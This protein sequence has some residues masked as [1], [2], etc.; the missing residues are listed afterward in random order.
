MGEIKS[1][2]SKIANKSKFRFSKTG[3][4][5][6][7]ISNIKRYKEGSTKLFG[8]QFRFIDSASFCGM[9]NEIILNEIYKFSCN[10]PSPLII[11]CGANVGVSVLYFKKIYP[12]SRILAFE[13]DPNVFN[14]LK[15]NLDRFKFDDIHLM[16]KAVAKES[17]LVH[18]NS[19]G[20]DGGRI[21]NKG[22]IVKE[23]INIESISLK[24]FLNEKV[25]FLKIDIEGAEYEVISDCRTKLHNVD[26]MFVEYHSFIGEEQHLG[27]ILSI[28][29]ENGFRF[30]IQHANDFNYNPFMSIPDY[31]GADNLLNIFAYRS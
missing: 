31:Q 16:N 29:T 1:F 19:E 3:K 27:N 26:R 2:A 30:Y 25:D 22:N 21:I 20:A 4:E 11:D 18:F 12:A 5:L 7:R 24:Q 13:A 14:I 9:Y 10:S 8:G 15:S 6:S 17:G 28:L 23:T